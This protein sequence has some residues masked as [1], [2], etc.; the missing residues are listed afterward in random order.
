MK[1]NQIFVFFTVFFFL[2]SLNT[3]F[4]QRGTAR[5]EVINIRFAS[6]LPRS[7]DWGR[8][9]DRMAADW[10]KATNSSV[11]VVVNHDGREGN[12]TKML[13]SLSSDAIQV[14]LFTSAGISEICPAVMNLSVP[15]MIKNERELDAVMQNI[16][17]ELERR[18][19]NEFVILAWS[20]G[21]WV[22]IFS[23]EGILT[24][25][26]LKRQKLGTTA[27]L[28]DMN[29]VFRTMGFNMVET[30][31][32]S[33]GTR[34]ATNTIN[35]VYVIPAIIAPMQLHRN[36]S[37]MLEMPIAP[38]MGAIVMNRVTWNKLSAA[39]QQEIVKVTKRIATEFDATVSRT[40]ANAISA[41]GRDGLNV[42]RPSQTQQ[43]LWSRDSQ[44]A[45]P[46]LMGTI[47]DRDLYNRINTILE[48]VRSGR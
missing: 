23:K 2:F 15:F 11:R 38:V 5:S 35:A 17:P 24:P 39:Q 3:V 19:R 21:G 30:D 36:L 37:H 1:R 47:F 29:T 31:W 14:A 9:L 4:A 34:L 45:L 7:S 41:M 18:V 6:P 27:E 40:E 28:R 42:N 13:S 8:T 32:V 33:V 25:D 26:D 22:Y 48:R 46:S 44:I 16:L 12:E 43:D 10:E 20:K